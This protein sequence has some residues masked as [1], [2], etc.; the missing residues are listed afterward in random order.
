MALFCIHQ[1]LAM[2][3]VKK[4]SNAIHGR[5]FCDLQ[6]TF[7]LGAFLRPSFRTV[8]ISEISI[9]DSIKRRFSC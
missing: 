6:S 9:V 1:F 4:K 3:S 5:H 7:D 8:I 2:I